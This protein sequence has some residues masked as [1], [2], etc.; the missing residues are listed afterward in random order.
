MF[1]FLS[2]TT[3]DKLFFIWNIYENT[4]VL[5]YQKFYIVIWLISI[6]IWF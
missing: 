5:F 3:S 6:N 2:R 1:F 4:I